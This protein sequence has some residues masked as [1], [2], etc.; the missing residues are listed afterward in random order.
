VIHELGHGLGFQTFVGAGTG[1]L[2]SGKPDIFSHFMFDETTG[3]HWDEM[4][5]AQRQASAI[6][7]G[8]L[9]WDGF[10][11]TFRAP[12]VLGKRPELIVDPPAFSAGTY[13]VEEATFGPPLDE[14]GINADIVWV[15]D[16][17]GDPGDA[18]EPIVNGAELNGNIAFINRGTCSYVFKVAAAQ[19]S[20]AVAV[21]VANNVAGP[22]FS[23]TGSGPSITI[24][25]VMV[26]RDDG[27]MIREDLLGGPIHGAL[28]RNPA[29]LAGAHSSGRVLLYAPNP[30]SA[31]SSLSHFDTSAN[32]SL[33]MEPAITPGLH[34]NV[35]LTR[36]VFEDIGWLPRLTSV[37]PSAPAPGFLARSA[38]NPFHPATVISLELPSGG[39][40]RVEVYDLQGRLVKRLLNSWLPAGRHAV[41]WDGTDSR[42]KRAGAGVYFSR[43]TSGGLRT[44][45]RLVKLNG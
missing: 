17:V 12:N 33:L 21:I 19:A 45:Q 39:A 25:S 23:M 43:V 38:P 30:V 28:R 5:N 37:E 7:G 11:T 8:N 1:S 44:G 24:P 10:A 4:T 27:D 41:T 31:G 22:P 35:D 13:G 15:N 16:G 32:P 34:D 42:G 29:L 6:S 2:L 36:E 3:L 26:S 40:T 14:T 20:G 9:S 18:C